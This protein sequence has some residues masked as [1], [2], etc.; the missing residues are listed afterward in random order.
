MDGIR[1][2]SEED[3]FEFGYW[4][5][6]ARDMTAT[7]ILA[8]M[9]VVDPGASMLTR[10]ES[11]ELAD[12]SDGVA[13]RAGRANGWAFLMVEG[14]PVRANGLG[15]LSRISAGTEAVEFWCTVNSDMMFTYAKSGTIMV[16]FEPG[17]EY[18]REGADPDLLVPAMED[19]GLIGNEVVG[20]PE[21]QVLS[22]M[23]SR[24]G[25]DLSQREVLEGKLLSAVIP[26]R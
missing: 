9:G 6:F 17:R 23:E 18:E 10:I 26:G 12:E 15:D 5:I 20:D 4:V 13:V 21:N 2:I 8:R 19:A 14:G 22:M 25:L 3:H 7:E 24:F 16:R 11:N 1:W